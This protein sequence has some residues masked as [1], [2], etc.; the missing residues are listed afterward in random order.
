MLY[1]KQ[2]GDT[3][4]ISINDIHQVGAADCFLL[5]PIGEIA[6]YHPEAISRMIQDNGNGTTTVTL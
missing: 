4:A 5:S 6:L 3:N 2:A 1:V